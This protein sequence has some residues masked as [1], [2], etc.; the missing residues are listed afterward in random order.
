MKIPYNKPFLTGK[1]VDYIIQ[2]VNSGKLSGN[3]FFTN[4][5]HKYFEEKYFFKKNLMTSSC[6]DALEMAALLVDIQPEDEV[7]MPSYTF[8]STANAFVLRGANIIF[9][10]SCSSNPNLDT[11]KLENLISPRTRAIVV[12]H[13]AGIAVDMDRI[14][15]L[16][17]QYNLY[18]VEDAAQAIDSYYKSIPLG[19]IGHLGA[20]SFHDTKNIIS[21]EGGMLVINDRKF[22][23]R[24]EFIW[25]KGTN[26]AAFWRGEVSKYGWVD[27]GSS[28]L[29][30]EVTAAFLFAQLENMNQIQDARI[31][32]W[33]RYFQSLHPLG[34][35][36][37]IKLPF[38]PEFAT[39]NAHIFYIVC[40]SPDEKK[41]LLLYLNSR[42]I[43]AV[44]HYLCLHKSPFYSN[45][46][47]GPPLINAE[48]YEQQ[49]VRLPL[50]CDM[51]DEETGFVID[52]ILE[53]YSA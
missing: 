12:V 20:L 33:N 38:L 30:S 47:K 10:D 15:Q 46:Y 29:P 39:N 23:D 49:L 42:G 8:V 41:E 22:F 34:E 3:G 26:R 32:I 27:I 13:Y 24:A 53:F 2:A 14:M 28:F 51:T 50:Y 4:R 6:T 52:S 37:R 45:R 36:G 5:C 9:A 35:K 31:R 16:A 11:E 25:E 40:S 19:S 7:I 21:G 18:V 44:F 43:E 17:H 1:E 48:T